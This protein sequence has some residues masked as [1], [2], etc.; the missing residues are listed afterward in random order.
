[1]FY[2]DVSLEECQDLPEI[3]KPA[4][5]AEFCAFTRIPSIN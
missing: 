4:E 2:N 3:L 1:M 5:V